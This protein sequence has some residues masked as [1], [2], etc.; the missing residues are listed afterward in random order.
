MIL[1]SKHYKNI[2]SQK[3][4]SDFFHIL[5]EPD[6]SVAEFISQLEKVFQV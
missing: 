5:H 6:E 2:R 1:L 4:A 3:P